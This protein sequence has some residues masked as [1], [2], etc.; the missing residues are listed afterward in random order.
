MLCI[1][2]HECM[3][4]AYPP[5]ARQWGGT[6]QLG[7]I[8]VPCRALDDPCHWELVWPPGVGGISDIAT[9]DACYRPRYVPQH[10]FSPRASSLQSTRGNVIRGQPTAGIK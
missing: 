4:T 10:L 1:Y 6:I 5:C 3:L 7:A 2:I 9:L 8:K